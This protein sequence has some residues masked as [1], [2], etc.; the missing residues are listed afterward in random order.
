MGGIYYHYQNV[1]FLLVKALADD[2]IKGLWTAGL[3]AIHPECG[4]APRLSPFITQIWLPLKQNLRFLRFAQGFSSITFTVPVRKAKSGSVFF[5][6]FTTTKY[7]DFM[8][9]QKNPSGYER[10]NMGNLIISST[11]GRSANCN[12]RDGEKEPKC[13]QDLTV[14]LATSNSPI[15]QWQSMTMK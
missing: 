12:Q 4:R 7:S 13:E 15:K 6:F 11:A 3:D 1:S 10:T 2:Y 8:C 14:A 5:M 9:D